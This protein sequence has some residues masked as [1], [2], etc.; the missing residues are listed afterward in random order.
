MNQTFWIN[1]RGQIINCPPNGHY[2]YMK[3]N[4]STLFRREPIN[5]AEVHDI[6]YETGY[7][8]IQNHFGQLNIRGKHDAIVG[9]KHMLRDIIFER[10]ME[11]RNFV[12][13]IEYNN[14]AMINQFGQAF[15]FNMPD[16]YDDMNVFLN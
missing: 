14:K 13:N 8:H 16:Q 7:I 6:P 15:R 10:L 9:K 4:F 12:V 1:P 5:E 11:N 2:A 3:Q